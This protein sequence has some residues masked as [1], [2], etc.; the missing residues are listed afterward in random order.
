M[1]KKIKNIYQFLLTLLSIICLT[2]LCETVIVKTFLLSPNHWINSAVDS[3]YIK[4]LTTSIND[5]IEDVGMASGIKKDGLKDVI[6]EKD[7]QTD[8]DQF[9]ISAFSGKTYNIDKKVVETTV[10]T[11]VESYA[12]KENKP[13]NETNQASV[14]QFIDQVVTEYNGKIH[15]PVV[16]AIGLRVSLVEKLSNILLLSTGIVLVIL[17]ICLYFAGNRYKHVLIR[18]IAYLVTTTGLLLVSFTLFLKVTKPL[19]SLSIIDVNMKTWIQKS[20]SLPMS[21]QVIVSVMFLA[22]GVLLSVYSYKEYKRLEKR[23]FRRKFQEI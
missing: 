14:T 1:N 5:S 23:G 16:S 2:V 15:N 13:I 11:A 17:I 20:L 4:Q 8:F 7:V 3:Q 9:V 19:D 12:K 10:Q 22:L 21:I 6:T 18:N